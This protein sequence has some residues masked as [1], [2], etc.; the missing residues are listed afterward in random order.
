MARPFDAWSVRARNLA[1]PFAENAWR[2]LELEPGATPRDVQKAAK[3]LLARLRPGRDAPRMF[4]TGPQTRTV[5]QVEA[6]VAEL[7][8]PAR[9]ARQSIFVPWLRRLTVDGEALPVA[10]EALSAEL[11]REVDPVALVTPLAHLVLPGAGEDDPA[12]EGEGE[13]VHGG[14]FFAGDVNLAE[15]LGPPDVKAAAERARVLSTPVGKAPS[16]ISDAVLAVARLG[17]GRKLHASYLK[18]LLAQVDAGE[19]GAALR[20]Q[21][22]AHLFDEVAAEPSAPLVL[23]WRDFLQGKIASARKRL[24]SASKDASLTAGER[25]RAQVLLARIAVARGEDASWL[26][27]VD[28]PEADLVRGAVALAGGA[29]DEAR[30]FLDGAWEARELRPRV[31]PLLAQALLAADD[32][33]GAARILASGRGESLSWRFARAWLAHAQGELDGAL[34]GYREVLAESAD[35]HGAAWGV[36]ALSDDEAERTR[37]RAVLAEA[38]HDDPDLA[39]AL[40]ELALQDGALEEIER[41]LSALDETDEAQRAL[42]VQVLDRLGQRAQ[43]WTLRG[44]P[45]ERV[46]DSARSE[47]EQGDALGAL[48]SLAGLSLADPLRRRAARQAVLEA[49]AAAP[50]SEPDAVVERVLGRVSAEELALLDLP[51]HLY[52]A[53]RELEYGDR[54]AAVAS[55]RRH[56]DSGEDRHASRLFEVL[57]ARPG[58]SWPALVRFL[59]VLL[60]LEGAE[61]PELVDAAT[62]SYDEVWEAAVIAAAVQGGAFDPGE[63]DGGH[64][65]LPLAAGLLLLR[66]GLLAAEWG[67]CAGALRSARSALQRPIEAVERAEHSLALARFPEA[68]VE[69]PEQALQAL[70]LA[71]DD[72]AARAHDIA[73]WTHFLAIGAEEDLGAPQLL[74][75]FKAWSEARRLKAVGHPALPLGPEA[76]DDELLAALAQLIGAV[77]PARA[78]EARAALE[79]LD[80]EL[81]RAALARAGW[82]GPAPERREA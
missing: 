18:T 10:L 66:A 24:G 48:R 69:D 63:F 26:A 7:A 23:G 11:R 71:A 68:V 14:R 74:R 35:H 55:L 72:P 12:A 82:A 50:D 39:F 32:V 47:L 4:G 34:D 77:G 42:K 76:L 70:Q 40:M 21:E 61:L 5:A 57:N 37:A 49:L 16:A 30:K 1:R 13:E 81:A 2:V 75:V 3:E 25:A 62:E 19:P 64:P 79:A 20:M 36:A 17:K 41:G 56:L 46:R 9:A 6:A 80:D 29:V 44:E 31:A 58:E 28:S 78:E 60:E 15:A 38:A 51:A 54:K 59:E 43:A 67:V 65:M 22:S 73:V 45:E 52:R 33:E 27:L 53:V 8:E